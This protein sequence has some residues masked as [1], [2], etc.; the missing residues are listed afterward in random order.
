MPLLIFLYLVSLFLPLSLAAVPF[1]HLDL[2]VR[3]PPGPSE[4]K[5]S[6]AH[7]L[8]DNYIFN[9]R[10]GWQN[11]NISDLPYKYDETSSTRS[12]HHGQSRPK[13]G[14]RRAPVE[15]SK[16]EVQKKNSESL[17]AH[18]TS[19]MENIIKKLKGIGKAQQ[20]TITW[21]VW[22]RASDR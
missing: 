20:V 2:E 4:L 3:S 18:I 17:K 8:G 14:G 15:V 11:V 12:R 7:N 22:N 13:K 10:D 9:P 1:P 5:Y 6:K 19:V 16:H 21:Y